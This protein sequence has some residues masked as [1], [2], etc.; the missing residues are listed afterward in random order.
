MSS[1]AS[2]T[3]R[4]GVAGV[5][6]RQRGRTTRQLS[7]VL[8]DLGNTW[9]RSRQ[10]PRRHFSPRPQNDLA[11]LSKLL[12][13]TLRWPRTRHSAPA[14]HHR[15]ECR[16]PRR[17]ALSGPTTS[18]TASTGVLDVEATEQFTVA[19]TPGEADLDLGQGEIF[20]VQ[21]TDTGNDPVTLNLIAGHTAQRGCR[22]RSG[23]TP[24]RFRRTS[25]SRSP[26]TLT[27]TLQSTTYFELNVTAAATV[28]QHTDSAMIAVRPSV[29]DV[30]SVT[31]SPGRSTLATRCRCRRRS[32]TPPMSRETSRRSRDPRRLGQCGG[33]ADGR[34]REPCAGQRRP[35]LEPGQVSH[36]R[37]GRTG[38]TA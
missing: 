18:S 15:R 2:R 31:A 8:S 24:S 38:F 1:S 30:L 19:L 6:R 28:A 34:V 26:I 12:M 14:D 3:G 36:D 22:S 11:N 29:A 10:R 13:P 7:S 32:S 9:P 27:Q 5:D 16:Q 25:R 20:S 37:A 33:H 4:R 35:Q 23:R 17:H 21:L